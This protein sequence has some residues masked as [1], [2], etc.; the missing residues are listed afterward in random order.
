MHFLTVAKTRMNTQHTWQML[1]ISG[2]VSWPV[3]Y[4]VGCNQRGFPVHVCVYSSAV[5]ACPEVV[6]YVKVRWAWKRNVVC[7]GEKGP[8]LPLFLW[9]TQLY[10][11][12]M[13]P[14]FNRHLRN[15]T[16]CYIVNN[17]QSCNESCFF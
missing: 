14:I 5:C 11:Y 8:H 15:M 10:S 3:S 9:M 13:L 16:Q 1:C 4:I 7:Q 2:V 12:L 17:F 6:G